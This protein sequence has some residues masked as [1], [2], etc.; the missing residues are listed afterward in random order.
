MIILILLLITLPFGIAVMKGAPYLPVLKADQTA[1]LELSGLS[2]GQTIID[3]GSGDGRFLLAAA[4]LG[5]GAIGYEINPFL[6]VASRALTWRYRKTVKIHLADFWG[7][8]LPPAEAIYVFLLDRHM[9]P[10]DE[11]LTREL[12][13]PTTVI[14]YIFAIPSRQADVTTRNA[15]K[16]HY[17]A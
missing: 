11:K 10:L 6:V 9:G 8:K 15:F 2:P 12:T 5:Y 1:L 14:S 3:L 7:A 17:K 16:Y 13:S 4:R